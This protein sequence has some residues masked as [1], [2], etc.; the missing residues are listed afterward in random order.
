MTLIVGGKLKIYYTNTS[1]SLEK[2]GYG[3]FSLSTGES[4][5]VTYPLLCSLEQ[6]ELSTVITASGYHKRMYSNEECIIYSSHLNLV[7]YVNSP[8]TVPE[9]LLSH[10]HFI[11]GLVKNNQM[12]LVYISR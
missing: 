9:D 4:I 1:Y 8:M 5:N 7:N 12:K 10:V 2:G 3:A 6:M 11:R